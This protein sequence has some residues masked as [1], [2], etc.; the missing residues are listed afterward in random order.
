MIVSITKM[1]GGRLPLL[2]DFVKTLQHDM[3]LGRANLS[4]L[5][6][7]RVRWQVE[8]V[9][10]HGVENLYLERRHHAQLVERDTTKRFSISTL[11][12]LLFSF[13]SLVPSTSFRRGRCVSPALSLALPSDTSYIWSNVA[14][15]PSSR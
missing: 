12:S 2:S 8:L 9:S 3:V 13:Q 10:R 4:F 1:Y 5:L 11:K 14:V 15:A 7:D 6:Q